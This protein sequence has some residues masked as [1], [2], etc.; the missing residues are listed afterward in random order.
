MLRNVENMHT[1][2]HFQTLLVLVLLY[3]TWTISYKNFDEMILMLEPRQ[4]PDWT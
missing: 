3:K 4:G 1:C 2:F